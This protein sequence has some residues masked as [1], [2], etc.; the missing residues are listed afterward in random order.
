MLYQFYD[1]VI[2]DRFTVSYVL[3][4]PPRKLLKTLLKLNP[5]KY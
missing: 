5:V 1:I 4:G 3:Y 2:G